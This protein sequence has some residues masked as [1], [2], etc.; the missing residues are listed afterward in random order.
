MTKKNSDTFESAINQL[1]TIIQH[2]ENNQIDLESALNQY[3]HGMELVK[4]CQDKLRDVEQKIKIL[5]QETNQLKDFNA[6]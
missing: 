6:E 3:K 1:E 2:I 4:F 5:D